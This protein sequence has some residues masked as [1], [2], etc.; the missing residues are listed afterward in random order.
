[1]QAL[2][3]VPILDPPPISVP[4]LAVRLA[5]EGLPVRA[6]ARSLKTPSDDI[7]LYL[8]EARDAGKITTI[9]RD[10]WPPGQTRDNRQA[11]K[12]PM[13]QDEEALRFSLVKA[14]RTTRLETVLLAALLRRDQ[15]T[16]SQ[17]HSVLEEHRTTHSED[18]TNIKIIDVVICKMRKKLRDHGI[19]IETIWAMGYT[20]GPDSKKIANDIL[21][22]AAANG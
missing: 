18:P 20:I 17:L 8:S 9:P 7:Y 16:R 6:I 3:I 22:Q 14:F 4:D 10:D 12:T 19:V 2:D 21:A 15:L 1:M 5:D 13:L 11:L